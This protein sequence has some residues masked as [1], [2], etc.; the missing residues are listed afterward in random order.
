MLS[1]TRPGWSLC[2]YSVTRLRSG[3]AAA[4]P[5]HRFARIIVTGRLIMTRESIGLSKEATM[6]PG[7]LNRTTPLAAV[8]MF[9]AGI[10]P[11]V[12]PK[13]AGAP[14]GGAGGM[15]LAIR[16]RDSIRL[17]GARRSGLGGEGRRAGGQ[18]WR[19]RDGHE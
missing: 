1:P 18:R 6:G 19:G 2:R 14:V 7:W 9:L 3:F 12:V 10:A 11:C 15:D 13:A 5:D 8:C 4:A 16:W 17:E